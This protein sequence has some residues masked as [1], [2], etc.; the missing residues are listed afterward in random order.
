MMRK[1]LLNL[2][3][4]LLLLSFSA[5]D[6]NGQIKTPAPSPSSELKQTVGLTDVT[7]VYSRPNVKGR[8]IFAEDGLV[9]FG[10]PWRLGANAATK[11]SFSE[12]VMIAGSK[13][14][15]GDYAVL[16]TP[17]AA[18]WKFMFYPYES[19]NWGS[20]LEKEA[21]AVASLKPITGD[22]NVE[23]MSFYIANVQAAS[24]DI[25]F[26]WEK[27]KVTLPL[28]A[29]TDKQVMASIESVLNGPS[30]NDYFAAATYYHESGK[31][32][33]Q[34]LAWVEKATAGDEP[35]FWQVRRKALILADLGKKEAAVKAAQLSLELAEKAGNEDYVRMNKKSIEEWTSM[36]K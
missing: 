26:S 32:L 21:A 25:V 13:L 1:V 17:G 27:T 6:L 3:A 9:P 4:M 14:K 23:T 31:D 15:A 28:E 24:A 30:Q 2:S 10:K 7:I 19:G 12:D 20:Y 29:D 16:A 8:A 22:K 5:L 11:F 36:K 34:A 33:N 18:E 35:R